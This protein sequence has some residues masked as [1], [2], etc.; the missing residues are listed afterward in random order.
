VNRIRRPRFL[1][2]MVCLTASLIGLSIIGRALLAAPSSTPW[3]SFALDAQHNALSGNASQALHKIHWKTAVD[4]KPQYNGGELLIHYGSPLVTAQNTV[5]VPVKTGATSGFQVEARHAN[6]GSLMWSINSDY[7]LPAHNWTPEFGPV[8]TSTPRLYFPGAGGT[9]MY[10]DKPDANNGAQGRLAFYGIKEYDANQAAFQSQVQINTPLSADALGNI[11]FGFVVSGSTPVP[12]QSGIARISASG[13][14]TWVS[15]AAAAGDSSMTKVPHNCAP[16]LSADMQTLYV[17]V[18]NG[19]AGYLVALNSGTLA[20]VAKVRLKDPKSSQDAWVSDDASATP[21]VDPNG[22]VYYGVLENPFPEN[23]DRG[24]LLH[25]DSHLAV[26]KTPG[27]FGWDD[28]ASVVPSSMVPS[29]VGT[30]AHLL[31]TKYNNYIGIGTG[32]GQNKIAVLD[33]GAT[34]TD[35]V[36]G[37]TVMKEVLTIL[38]PT[39]NSSGGVREWCINTAA[40]DPATKSILA[41]SEDGKLYRW[42]LTTNTLSETIVLTSGLGEAYTPTLIGVDGTVYAISNAT[43]FAIGN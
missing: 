33:P 37:V 32:N 15:A 24:W 18:S 12:L 30:S 41:G 1:L 6:N 5:I 3:L 29:Y 17:A 25:F 7:I 42:N 13:A 36:T 40:V 39:A 27:A 10:R 16:A 21:T 19:S 43:L 8:L 34:E 4:L 22:D 20:T 35:P 9:V 38:G 23:N 28:T 31:M 14:G 2:L 11:Y 26:T